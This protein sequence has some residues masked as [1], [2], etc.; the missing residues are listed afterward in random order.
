M[1]QTRAASPICHI[2][3]PAPDLEKAKAFYEAVFGWTVQADVPGAKYWFFEAGNVGGAF[4]GDR[5]PAPRSMMLL[6][7]VADLALVLDHVRRSGGTVTREPSAIGEA[8]PGDDAYF[9]DPNGNEI[10]VYAG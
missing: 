3:I 5:V 8:D 2:V 10:G 7:K 4:D 6:I 1:D 9:L